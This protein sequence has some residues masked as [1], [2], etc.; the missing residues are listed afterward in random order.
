[1]KKLMLIAAAVCFSGMAM[2][3]SVQQ[4]ESTDQS[5]PKVVSVNPASNSKAPSCCAS[6]AGKSCSP[7][8]KA[9]CAPKADQATR[10]EEKASAAKRAET[11]K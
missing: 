1:M 7:K 5:D 11:N 3:Q 6:M 2:S 10:K 4:N 8:D 9:E